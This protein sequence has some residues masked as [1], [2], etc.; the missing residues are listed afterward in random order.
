MLP[1]LQAQ[2]VD[3]APLMREYRRLN[4]A[5]SPVYGL[6]DRVRGADTEAGRTRA[7][8][9]PMTS[10]EGMSG[11]EAI[12]SGQAELAVPGGLIGMLEGGAMAADAPAAASAGLMPVEDA[13]ME[14]MGVA[15]TAMLGGG[16]FSAP[17]GALRAG[18]MRNIIDK[19]QAVADRIRSEY[20]VEPE[21]SH[22][23]TSWGESAYLRAKLRGPD[24]TF[25]NAGFRLSDHE[26]G[27]FRRATD[28]VGTIINN[29]DVTPESLFSVIQD[30]YNNALPKMEAAAEARRGSIAASSEAARLWENTTGERKGEIS[31]IYKSDPAGVTNRPWRHLSPQ[32]KAD[33]AYSRGLTTS[34]NRDAATG[35]VVL[36]A[37]R[38]EAEAMARRILEMRAA[39]R[40]GDVTDEMMA[41]ADPQYMFN[42]TPLP[43]DYESRMGRAIQAGFDVNDEMYRG[44]APRSFFETGRDQRDKIGVTMSSRPDV[45]ASYVPARGEGG[46]YPII[47]RGQNDAVID[48]Q[49]TNWNVIDRGVNVNFQGEDAALRDYIPDSYF[50]LYELMDNT[51]FMDTNDLSR[52]FQGYGAD[53]VRFNDL[54]DRGGSAKYYGPE[55]SMPSDVLMVADPSN[56]RSRFARFDPEFSHLANLSAANASPGVGLLQMYQQ[57][58]LEDRARRRGLLP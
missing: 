56:V 16:A 24:N 22:H 50:D 4:S 20:G 14:A 55:S 31:Q 25:Y 47:S 19:T 40:A 26:T 5:L 53:R 35:A 15:G 12:R 39:G 44:D 29:D 42:N 30:G 34:A 54:V 32:E 1:E 58:Q 36:P 2:G 3:V 9:L 57:Q 48:A 38:N 43:M 18:A 6:I 33:Y 49:G 37:A 11:L 45:A 27:D 17:R 46:V 7:T 52:A 41:A 10:P 23:P 8:L 28:E 21:V 51:D 13:P